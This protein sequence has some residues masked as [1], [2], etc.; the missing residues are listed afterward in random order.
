MQIQPTDHF[1][2]KRQKVQEETVIVEVDKRNE[3]GDINQAIKS[4]KFQMIQPSR[5][6]SMGYWIIGASYGN[7]PR[8]YK[9]KK[10]G[11]E[12]SDEEKSDG[13]DWQRNPPDFALFYML[14]QRPNYDRAIFMMRDT[15]LGDE[16]EPIAMTGWMEIKHR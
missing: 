2:E 8:K 4:G 11:E 14:Q 12:M 3:V 5:L 9:I 16:T 10:I 13:Y 6:R 15:R 1:P 7:F